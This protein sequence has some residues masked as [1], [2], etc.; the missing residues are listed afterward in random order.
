M[1]PA[2]LR[3]HRVSPH[4]SL[5]Q[6]RCSCCSSMR[7][8]GP[9]RST[10][11]GWERSAR[12]PMAADSQRMA[13]NT[14]LAFVLFAQGLIFLDRDR[15]TGGL[16]ISVLRDVHADHRVRRPCRTHLRRA[17]L[18]QLPGS[19]RDVAGIRHHVHASGIR[20]AVLA[21]RARGAGARSRRRSRGLCSAATA[22]GCGS[23][24]VHIHDA[25]LRRRRE[26]AIRLSTR[27]IV[28]RG[29]GHGGVPAP[30]RVERARFERHR[31]QA[32]RAVRPRA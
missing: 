20:T 5:P 10:S 13:I 8:A 11:S 16:R 27:R 21:A 1:N 18:L 7:W 19:L 12:H 30:H 4:L 9:P 28:V 17:G 15:R 14:A 29:C 31:S 6:S 22:P 24:P 32:R 3:G 2:R 25:P 23:R 26:R